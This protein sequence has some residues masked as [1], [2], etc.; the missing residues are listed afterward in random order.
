MSKTRT[1][2]SLTTCELHKISGQRKYWLLP[3]IVMLLIAGG[4]MLSI[5]PGSVIH[6]SMANY[7]YT[8]LSWLN[9]FFLPLAIFMLTSD[10]ISDE[11]A[12]QKIRIMLTLP[13]FRH[14][15]LLAKYTA[16]IIYSGLL[17]AGSMVLSTALSIIGGGIVSIS[18]ATIAIVYLTSLL[19]VLTLTA[20]A[21]LIAGI[22][23]SGTSAF[24]FC[25]LVYIGIIVTGLLFTAVSPIL[26][27]SYQNISNMMIG[28]VIPIV[29]L[30]LGVVTLVGYL[31]IFTALGI[32]AFERG[33][34]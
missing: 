28:S 17:L 29:P 23:K 34:F 9:T 32:M 8:A 24:G 11:I 16:I 22:T 27:T 30:V 21:G 26:F 3:L 15:V 20:F 12:S 33:E 1:F 6:F 14:Q 25:L 5:L 7:P 2:L 19:P 10:L 4:A 31:A 18:I 13:A